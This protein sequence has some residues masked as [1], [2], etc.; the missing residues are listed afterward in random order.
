MG[1]DP[2]KEIFDRGLAGLV[3]ERFLQNPLRFWEMQVRSLRNAGERSRLRN[4]FIA[5]GWTDEV[6]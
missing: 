6:A 5:S 1:P 2:P 4:N 3:S